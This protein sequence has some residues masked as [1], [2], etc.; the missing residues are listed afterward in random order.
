[1]KNYP[2]KAVSLMAVEHLRFVPKGWCLSSYG[3]YIK[4]MLMLDFCRETTARQ[5]YFHDYGGG[6]CHHG[7][8]I[9]HTAE[10]IDTVLQVIDD[11]L[12]AMPASA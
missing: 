3:T 11:A 2:A 1:M 5:V 4:V 9:S 10:E 12:N 7:F 6:A 8:S